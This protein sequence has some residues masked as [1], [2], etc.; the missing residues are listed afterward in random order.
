MIAH[1]ENIPGVT[2]SAHE[3]DSPAVNLSVFPI[4]WIPTM[5]LTSEPRSLVR[6]HATRDLAFRPACSPDKL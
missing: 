4:S 6:E 5:R 2:S 1:N 3:M